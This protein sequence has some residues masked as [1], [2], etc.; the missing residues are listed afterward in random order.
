MANQNN[1]RFDDEKREEKKLRLD[2]ATRF[3]LLTERD[4]IEQGNKLHQENKDK[5]WCIIALDVD[6]F[7]LFNRY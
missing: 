4:F 3:S 5:K 2:F 1:K 6:H 7:D